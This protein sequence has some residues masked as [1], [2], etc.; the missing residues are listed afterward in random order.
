MSGGWT[1]PSRP[2]EP[3][4]VLAPSRTLRALLDRACAWRSAEG[5]VG[6][7]GCR[8]RSNRRIELRSHR[9]RLAVIWV[10][11]HLA[12]QEDA[13]DAAQGPAVGVTA[14]PEGLVAAAA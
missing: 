4:T 14:R 9:H 2:L 10:E 5:Q 13:G 1:E 7:E 11:Q 3:S 6:T 12:P 8:L